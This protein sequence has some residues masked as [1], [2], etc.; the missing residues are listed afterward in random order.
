MVTDPI[1]PTLG[2]N[3]W[4]AV[5]S[6]FQAGFRRPGRRYDVVIKVVVIVAIVAVMVVV[7]VV[8]VVVLVIIVG[9]LKVE[10]GT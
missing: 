8:V 9:L 10:L 1:T 7:V 4:L 5:I 2:I 6:G 3:L